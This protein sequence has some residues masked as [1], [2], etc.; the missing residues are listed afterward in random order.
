MSL[1]AASAAATGF[2]VMAK[3][4][5]AICNLDCTYCYYLDKERLYPGTE[6]WAMPEPTLERFIADYIAAQPGDTVTFAWQGGEPTLLGLDYF[7]KVAELQ[8]THARGKRI[9]NAFQTNGVLVDADWA[10]FFAREG[11]LIGLSIDGPEHLHDRL[12][13]DKGQRATFKRVMRGLDQLKQ[14]G[15]EFNTLTCVHRE[16]ADHPTAIYRFLKDI[17]SGFIQFIPIVERNGA[18][19]TPH[20]LASPDDLDAAVT[21]W[22][23]RPHQYGNF[24]CTIYDEWVR[25]DVGEVFVQLFDVAL[26]A[27]VGMPPPLCV[28]RETCA[29]AMAIEHNGD[30][31]SCDHFVYPEYRLGNI[32]EDGL[33]K[34]AHSEQQRAFGQAK[35]D[36]L[37]RYCRECDVR[38]A[39]NGE[40]PKHRFIHTPDGEPG[41]NY[42]C[43]AYKQFFH[44]IDEGMRVMA[45]EL[46][47]Q[48]PAAGVM[49][50]MRERDL[51]AAGKR[52]PGPN[53]PCH[54]GSGK[55]FKKC[56][57][58]VA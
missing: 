49:Q 16:N 46:H 31:Y 8:R 25:R 11:W 37:P 2:H 22:S 36:T 39:C 9:E 32:V 28:F 33:E 48:R 23:V 13:V 17:G 47:A 3:P 54:C 27:W 56:C 42:L 29:A 4:T 58:R 6:Q 51:A 35:R 10:T 19:E 1:T 26:A 14:H 52:A 44:H 5:G 41:L 50:Y 20:D 53:D 7:R 45:A 43:G 15:V 57:G 40:C 21:A 38:F 30:L 55:K 12:R 34:L 24:L 18:G